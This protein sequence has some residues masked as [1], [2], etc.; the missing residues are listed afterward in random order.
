MKN[1]EEKIERL[2]ASNFEALGE[3]LHALN[4]LT[5]ADSLANILNSLEKQHLINERSMMLDIYDHENNAKVMNLQAKHQRYIIWSLSIGAV[6]LLL[7]LIFMIFYIRKRNSLYRHIVSNY[8]EI[9]NFEKEFRKSKSIEYNIEETSGQ[10]IK[11]ESENDKPIKSNFLDIEKSKKIYNRLC[12]LVENERLYTDPNFTRE[13][14]VERLQTNRTYLSQIIKM[15]T[16]KNY[17]Q[18]INSYRI[19]EAIKILS[20][21]EKKDYSLKKLS[22]ELG[23]ISS[24]TFSKVFQQTVGMSP[25]NFRRTSFEQAF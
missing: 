24:N 23:F 18:F 9:L 20:D 12:E 2:K 8:K 3:S 16:G 6:I 14:L 15:H 7:F 21:P 10:E 11:S 25:S 13:E 19:K 4:S 5:K 17:S 22:E 1:V